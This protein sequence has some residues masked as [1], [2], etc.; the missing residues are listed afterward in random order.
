M[1]VMGVGAEGSAILRHARQAVVR[2]AV[3][4]EPCGRGTALRHYIAEPVA[5]G[6]I[7]VGGIAPRSTGGSQ[8]VGELNAL[9]PNSR[10]HA[11]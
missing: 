2:G 7:A 8:P 4:G 3:A 6:I 5:G 11:G 10:C 9:S 1:A